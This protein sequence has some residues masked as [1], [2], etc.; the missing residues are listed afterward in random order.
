MGVG[1]PKKTVQRN[2]FAF[3][4]MFL[5]LALALLGCARK[6]TASSPA[7]AAPGTLEVI[8]FDVR[9]GD[10]ALIRFPNGKT[11]LVDGGPPES[12]Q[13]LVD[14]LSAR[15]IRELD[16]MVA[17]H[18]H[19]DHIG[20]LIGV[21]QRFRVKEVWD[22][23]FAYPSPVYERYLRAVKASGA[24]FRLIRSGHRLQPCEG[25]LIEVYAPHEPFLKG[26]DSDANNNSL[27]FRLTYGKVRFLFTGDIQKEGRRRLYVGRSDLRAE[28]L[29]VAHHGSHNGT[30]RA[31]LARVRPLFAV[32]SCA[33]GNSYGH[34]HQ[35]CLR[36]LR[37]FRVQ[38][39]RT[40]LQGTVT[41]TVQDSRLVVNT[42]NP[43][44]SALPPSSAPISTSMEA[45]AE[46][47]G[48]VNS[49][50]YHTANCPRLPRP[51]NRVRFHSR[52]EAERRGYRPHTS[53][54]GL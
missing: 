3:C 7:T 2:R 36:D 42:E 44:K 16:W 39:Y 4:L 14:A 46:Y 33:R 45:Q 15:A 37:R 21:L 25:C 24:R 48:N 8:F 29:K 53:C 43:S 20:G 19:S 28:V 31:F 30:D 17:S 6:E 52:E 23:G 11:M 38:T 49:K 22:S 18:P 34:P 26:T 35:E 12:E 54:V 32:I 5:W 40:D 1:Y 41:I 51:E 10:A 50:V 47:I 27:V 13:R 9:Q